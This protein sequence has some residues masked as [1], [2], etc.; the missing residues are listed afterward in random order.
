M[1]YYIIDGNNLI[2][3]IKSLQQ[4]QKK[5]KQASREKLIYFLNRYFTGKK[6]KLSLHLDG[7]P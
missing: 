6:V 2:G 3:R 5:D 4:L 1:N 7:H